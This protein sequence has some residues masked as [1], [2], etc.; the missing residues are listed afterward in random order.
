[1]NVFVIFVIMTISLVIFFIYLKKKLELLPYYDTNLSKITY[2]P[3]SFQYINSDK[4]DQRSLFAKKTMD[5]SVQKENLLLLK[6]FLES[7]KI[8]YYIDCG[9]LLGAVRDKDFIKGDTDVD[10]MV[11]KVGIQEIR[12]KLYILER[13]GFI[14]FRNSRTSMSMSLLRKGEYI[15]FYTFWTNIP[16]E[17]IKYPFLGTTF[18]IPKYYEE[19]LTESYIIWKT[20]SA[21]KGPG[22]WEKGMRKYVANHKIT[23]LIDD[24]VNFRYKPY[25]YQKELKQHKRNGII[26]DESVDLNKLP[27]IFE[28]FDYEIHGLLWG[29]NLLWYKIWL[30]GGVRGNSKTS[31][32]VYCFP[33]R[34]LYY[35]FNQFSDLHLGE[36]RVLVAMGE[37]THS[38]KLSPNQKNKMMRKFSTIFWE[39]NTDPSFETLPMGLNLLYICLNGLEKTEEIIKCAVNKENRK[40][41]II[42]GWNKL[43]VELENPKYAISSRTRLGEFVKHT[44]QEGWYD[45]INYPYIKYYE[46]ISNYKFMVC[47]T[48]NGIQTP[49][50]FEAILVRTIPVVED[51]LAFRQLKELGLPLLIVK[52]W[53]ELS[54]EFLKNTS[55]NV[56]WD[57]AIY[58]CSTKGVLDMI[59]SKI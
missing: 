26:V 55:M 34:A 49:K 10:I 54:E 7:Q 2:E 20:P 5:N 1:M 38:S 19:Y 32:V 33:E 50:I 47:P 36:K 13:L 14:S 22:N 41:C 30:N 44:E 18:P 27:S 58:L 29:F 8:R 23:T 15:D 51:E 48:G 52:N 28:G 40:L 6:D 21:D 59:Y 16:F 3:L 25:K 12:S 57:Y 9:T 46:G 39:A 53:S 56:N 24:I 17:L 35:N 45:F 11:S 4:I 37:D 43:S 42:P 31:K